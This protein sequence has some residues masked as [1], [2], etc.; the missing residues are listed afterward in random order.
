LASYNSLVTLVVIA[1]I[2]ISSG[3]DIFTPE[4]SHGKINSAKKKSRAA[5]EHLPCRVIPWMSYLSVFVG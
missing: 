5:C 3:S 2:V 4:I 1:F